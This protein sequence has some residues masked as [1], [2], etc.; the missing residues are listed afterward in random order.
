M[1]WARD[2]VARALLRLSRWFSQRGERK[3]AE[4]AEAI[5]GALRDDRHAEWYSLDIAWHVPSRSWVAPALA[6]LER[7]GK[8]TSRFEDRRGGH[9]SRRRLYKIAEDA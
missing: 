5:L 7:Q 6:R 4:A 1:T 8:V 9:E 3:T 2:K